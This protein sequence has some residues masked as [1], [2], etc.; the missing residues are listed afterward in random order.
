MI[1]RQ[2]HQRSEDDEGEDEQEHLNKRQVVAMERYWNE[3]REE[4]MELFENLDEYE[5]EELLTAY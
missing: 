3:Q 5:S 2:K 1:K 4:D